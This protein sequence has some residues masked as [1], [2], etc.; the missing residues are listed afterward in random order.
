VREGEVERR[1]RE[2]LDAASLQNQE[3]V[4]DVRKAEFYGHRGCH[5]TSWL[6]RSR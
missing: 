3:M 4:R 1:D 5:F 2:N 6:K